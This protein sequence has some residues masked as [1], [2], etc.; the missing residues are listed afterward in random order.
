MQDDDAST[1]EDLA[2]PGLGNHP[3][4]CKPLGQAACTQHGKT[5]FETVPMTDGQLS[6]FSPLE[7][8]I[9]H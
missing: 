3:L 4:A 6:N 1:E 5:S 8:I 9:S 2:A 7:K